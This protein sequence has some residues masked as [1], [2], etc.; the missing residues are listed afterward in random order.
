[1]R[2]W[3]QRSVP[4]LVW[5]LLPLALFTYAFGLNSLDIPSNGDEHVY[6]HIARMTA[7]SGHWLPLQSAI[8]HT[9]NTKP[10]LLFWQTM[11]AG[12]GHWTLGALRWPS[13]AYT[14][15]T[16][17]LVFGVARREARDAK[18]GALAVLLYLGCYSVYRYGRPVLT[19]A[20]ETFW[21]SVM[22]LPWAMRTREALP[23]IGA[24]IGWG[25]CLGIACLYKSFVLIVPV[26]VY[27]LYVIAG[28]RRSGVPGRL[29]SV[30]LLSA[31]ALLT[32]ALWPLLDPDPS[33]IWR[34]FVVGE[35]AQ[36]MGS[37]ATYVQGLW[38]GGSSVPGLFGALLADG[39]V[40]A[41]LLLGVIWLGVRNR[42]TLTPTERRLWLW[43]IVLFVFFCIP[44]QRSGRYLLPVL[45]A[46]AILGA[47]RW[48]QIGRGWVRFAAAVALLV[49]VAIATLTAW[50]VQGPASPIAVGVAFWL[51]C[52]AA[53]GLSLAALLYTRL[54]VVGVSGAA[55]LIMLSMALFLRSY[56]APPG[57]FAATVRAQLVGQTVYAPCNF[58]ASEEAYRF[59][60]PGADIRSYDLGW[61]LT[62]LDLARHRYFIAR[63][64]LGAPVTCEGC[65][66]LGSRVLIAGRLSAD[67]W[68]DILRG[69][70][71]PHLLVQDVLWESTTAGVER[72]PAYAACTPDGARRHAFEREESK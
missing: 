10:P 40:L 16:A 9:R 2:S 72:T 46:L 7:D 14:W 30:V 29:L 25:L 5:W 63:Q 24:V 47:V 61:Q 71:L 68:H 66:R 13:V 67:E 21:L 56:D 62:P 54:G 36:K 26:A 60:L 15:L 41:P 8:E 48:A 52:A 27:Y 34:E 69:H 3:A 37:L 59:L 12:A 42:Q 57:P 51:A 44:S 18:T 70:V 49:S 4:S 58:V 17:L 39:G 53:I 33:A 32:C 50:A 45:P 38:H 23:S 19:D 65:R 6:L 64:P 28:R 35:N 55:I 11:L 31:V 20:P 43:V 1:M 22:V